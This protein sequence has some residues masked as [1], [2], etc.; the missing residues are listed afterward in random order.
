MADIN[1]LWRYVQQLLGLPGS[2]DS[3]TD[4]TPA[5]P[6]PVHVAGPGTGLP[7]P[8]A[9]FDRKQTT[10]IHGTADGTTPRQYRG[11][12]GLQPWDVVDS[13]GLDYYAGSAIT[14]IC[15]HASSGDPGDLRKAQQ[16]LNA[17]INRAAPPADS[18]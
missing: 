15:R 7:D 1:D 4:S 12:N 2:E 9:T 3:M 14:L 11:R 17:M 6:P 8:D 10:L 13:F 16:F 18:S 5:V